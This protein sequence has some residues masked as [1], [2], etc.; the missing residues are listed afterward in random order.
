MKKYVAAILSEGNHLF[1]ASITI[2]GDGVK[3]RVPNFW[4]NEETFFSF[5]DI[6]GISL[7]TPNWY[8]VLTY[9]TISFNARGSWVQVHG[10]SKSDA[11][12]IKKI[13]EKMQVSESSKYNHSSGNYNE[14]NDYKTLQIIGDHKSADRFWEEDRRRKLENKDA[15]KKVIEKFKIMLITVMAHKLL[16]RIYSIKKTAD[17][18]NLDDKIQTYKDKLMEIIKPFANKYN[19][20]EIINSCMM[21]ARDKVEED[22]SKIWGIDNE[23]IIDIYR[24]RL[25]NYVDLIED[26]SPEMEEAEENNQ[27]NNSESNTNL[28]DVYDVSFL[29]I[30]NYA[31]ENYSKLYSTYYR[32]A[33]YRS[34][35]DFE[36]N[37][38]PRI[39]TIDGKSKNQFLK[40]I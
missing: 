28:D 4:K 34:I 29:V 33:I 36:S 7:E 23:D 35:R 25:E 12:E 17:S 21:L 14:I 32:I 6:T 19:Y 24:E 10:F 40:D 15:F 18:T 37:F 11:I 1:Q 13:I 9:S 16:N 20:N 31:K 27:R 30:D 22:L 5:N 26:E 38:K 3:L 2:L 8:S 39:I